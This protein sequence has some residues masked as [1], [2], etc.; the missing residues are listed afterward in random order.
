MKDLRQVEQ[1]TR[2]LKCNK[3]SRTF[4]SKDVTVGS[5]CPIPASTSDLGVSSASRCG[6]TLF[7]YD[8]DRNDREKRKSDGNA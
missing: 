8:A 3:C 4:N 2:I 5:L 6:G 7:E 1:S